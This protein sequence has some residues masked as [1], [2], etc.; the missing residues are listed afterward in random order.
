MFAA[1]VNEEHPMT[2]VILGEALKA[3]AVSSFKGYQGSTEDVDNQVFAVWRALQNRG[4]K[5]SSITG[6]VGSDD[7]VFSQP[8]RLF[9]DAITN[10]QANCID[11]TVVFASFLRKIQIDPFLVLMPG[12]AYL[13]YYTKASFDNGKQLSFLEREPKFL[14]TTMIGSKDLSKFKT[15]E[16]KNEISKYQF[17]LAISQG[18]VN[19]RNNLNGILDTKEMKRY[20]FIDIENARKTVKP[21][22]R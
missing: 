2:D 21:L 13:G 1:Y 3:N 18:M 16:A 4:I 9:E 20:L 5:Y 22:G 12:H 8:V 19:F 10:S 17:D 15:D 11:G 14:E 6:G 7:N